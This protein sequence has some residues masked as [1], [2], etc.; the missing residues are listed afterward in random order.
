[1][2]ASAELGGGSA[3]EAY[4]ERYVPFVTLALSGRAVVFR[5]RLPAY[6]QKRNPSEV[7]LT[8]RNLQ[9][10]R[11]LVT[12]DVPEWC[13]CPGNA[14]SISAARHARLSPN[15]AGQSTRGEC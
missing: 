3:A 13:A 7:E 1:M 5:L 9:A 2:A 11:D 14:V 8:M 15:A 10:S 4:P 6:G 12:G